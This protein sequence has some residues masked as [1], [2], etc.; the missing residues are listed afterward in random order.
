M[1]YEVSHNEQGEGRRRKGERERGGDADI[2]LLLLGIN[3]HGYGSKFPAGLMSYGCT[4]RGGLSSD[5]SFYIH[6]RFTVLCASALSKKSNKR[7]RNIQ[8]LI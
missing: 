5:L 6:P 4:Y 8:L 3:F 1:S 7:A 2:Y